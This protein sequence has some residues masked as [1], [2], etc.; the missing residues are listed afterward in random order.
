MANNSKLSTQLTKPNYLV[1]LITH[2]QTITCVQLFS[3]TGPDGLLAKEKE[4]INWIE[5]ILS[6]VVVIDLDQPIKFNLE[7]YAMSRWLI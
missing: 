1:D 6:F 5:I 4:E 7:S 2:E 3:C